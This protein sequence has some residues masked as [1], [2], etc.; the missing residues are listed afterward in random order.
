MDRRHGTFLVGVVAVGLGMGA[1][2][3]TLPAQQPPAGPTP[4]VQ[5]PPAAGMAQNATTAAQALASPPGATPGVSAPPSK[6]IPGQKAKSVVPSVAG[7]PGKQ[8]GPNPSGAAETKAKMER[9][10]QRELDVSR[11]EQAPDERQAYQQNSRLWDTMTGEERQAM[12]QV[13]GGRM[14]VE[15][16]EAYKRS[17]LNLNADQREMFDLRYRQERRRIEREVQEIARRE[18]ERRLP[19]VDEQMRKEFGRMSAANT[20]K[21]GATPAVSGSAAPTPRPT[22]VASAGPTAMRTVPLRKGVGARRP[23]RL[24]A[25]HFRRVPV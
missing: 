3:R 5:A 12:R 24:G 18:R 23:Y 11:E 22:P 14:Q 21:A 13:I 4:W 7:A 15:M 1:V 25:R 16:D 8:V 6:L 10:R 20:A 9:E 2:V 19:A 17:G